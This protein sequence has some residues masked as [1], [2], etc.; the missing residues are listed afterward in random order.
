MGWPKNEDG[1]VDWEFVFTNPETGFIPAVNNAKTAAAL[2]SCA[3]VVIDSLFSR[4]G[5]E[6]YRQAYKAALNHIF[7]SLQGDENIK[8]IRA[9]LVTMFHSIKE[10]RITRALE[11]QQ[12]LK[13]HPDAEDRRMSPDDPLSAIDVL[14]D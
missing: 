8:T 4:Q 7:L 11:Y 13:Q 9:R 3:T 2:E 10:N 1:S 14:I 12:S 6:E 5:D